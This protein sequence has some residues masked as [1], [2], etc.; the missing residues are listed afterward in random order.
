MPTPSLDAGGARGA[1]VVVVV[2]S[3]AFLDILGMVVMA[4][5]VMPWSP[6]PAGVVVVVCSR[7]GVPTVVVW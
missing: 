2:V 7:S 6:P 5:V 1:V 3:W 4:M